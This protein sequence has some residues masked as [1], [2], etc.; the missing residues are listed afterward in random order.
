MESGSSKLLSFPIFLKYD[1]KDCY[2]KQCENR[3]INPPTRSL[4]SQTDPSKLKINA[5]RIK[6][7]DWEAIFSVLKIENTL[8]E[9]QIYSK[10]VKRDWPQSCGKIY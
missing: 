1:F 6:L 10:K 9:I 7:C 2:L 8:K 3:N 4:A 5:D